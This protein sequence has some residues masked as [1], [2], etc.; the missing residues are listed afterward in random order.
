MERIRLLIDAAAEDAN[1]RRSLSKDPSKLKARFA[2]TDADCKA[3]KSAESLVT[4]QLHPHGTETTITFTT[5]STV[6][7]SLPKMR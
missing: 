3:L 7:G 1:I 2:F 6:T 4:N 5:A